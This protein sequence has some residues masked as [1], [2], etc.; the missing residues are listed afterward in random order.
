MAM[1]LSIFRIWCWLR[2]RL[3]NSAVFLT[4][5]SSRPRPRH[6]AAG[7]F[8][9]ILIMNNLLI[10]VIIGVLLGL[11][12]YSVLTESCPPVREVGSAWSRLAKETHP[13]P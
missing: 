11:V 1:V 9:I 8:F 3:G 6:G 2:V 7:V 12:A 4:R 10:G 5:A 13:P